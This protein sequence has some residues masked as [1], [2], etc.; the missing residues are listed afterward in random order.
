MVGGRHDTGG[1]VFGEIA[2]GRL[3]GDRGRPEDSQHVVTHLEGLADRVAVAAEHCQHVFTAAGHGRAH[4][5]GPPHG[6]VAGFAPRH[7][8]HLVQGRES[9]T[10][11]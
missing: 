4:L 5:Q 1:L 6:V 11:R 7:V 8:E 9:R 10:H 3:A 2:A